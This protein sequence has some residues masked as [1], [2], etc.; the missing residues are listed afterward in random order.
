MP[1]E[2][3]TVLTYFR[4]ILKSFISFEQKLY[5]MNVV[6]RWLFDETFCEA[7]I[8]FEYSVLC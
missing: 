4:Y 6:I 7:V 8:S 2:K 3:L 1:L 5:K